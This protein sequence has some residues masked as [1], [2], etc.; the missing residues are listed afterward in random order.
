MECVAAQHKKI[1]DIKIISEIDLYSHAIAIAVEEHP[2]LMVLASN[3][4]ACISS[5]LPLCFEQNFR[6]HITI[7]RM[8]RKLSPTHKEKL[9]AVL[10]NIPIHLV[11]EQFSVQEL[12]LYQSV[13]GLY[14]VLGSHSLQ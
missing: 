9:T 13:Q 7:G 14:N 1:D 12:C 4:R 5:V 11:S 10:K 8:R 2:D 6:P 3:M